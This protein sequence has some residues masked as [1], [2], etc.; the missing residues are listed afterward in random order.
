MSMIFELPLKGEIISSA[1][2]GR[3]RKK[4]SRISNI[5]EKTPTKLFHL[6]L[7]V[8]RR[9]KPFVPPQAQ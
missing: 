9:K 1:I 3:E 6:R 5:K 8:G 7:N 4:C 2:I